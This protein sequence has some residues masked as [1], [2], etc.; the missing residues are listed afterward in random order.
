MA[1][2]VGGIIWAIGAFVLR[3]SYQWIVAKIQGRRFDSFDRPSPPALRTDA[4]R[5]DTADGEDFGGST[6]T[7]YVTSGSGKFF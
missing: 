4:G 1:A 2:P 3:L 5:D 7:Q 6:H